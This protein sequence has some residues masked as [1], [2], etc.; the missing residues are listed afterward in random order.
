M[1][2]ENHILNFKLNS[3]LKFSMIRYMKEKEGIFMQYDTLLF[4]IDNTLLDFEADESQ[5]LK[6]LF[7]FVGIKLTDELHQKYSNYN[8]SLWQKLERNEITRDELLATRFNVF[9]KVNFNRDVTDLNLNDRYINYLSDG[10]DLMPH[11]TELLQ[12]L[13]QSPAI[14][15]E[16]ATNG[17]PQTQYKRLKEAEIMNYFDQ[18]FV[19]QEIGINKPNIGFYNY[20]ENHLENFNAHRTLMIG[21]S[22]TSDIQGGNNANI[23]SVWFNPQHLE[24]SSSAQPTYE[25]D[26]LLQIKKLI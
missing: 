3:R 22:L 26:D 7:D 5:A 18:I 4:D 16:I 17:V 23:D 8:K 20:I 11:A 6:R 19:S 2:I 21:D 25:I 13:K 24:N 10:H 1:N 14:R 9:F 12:F 15:L